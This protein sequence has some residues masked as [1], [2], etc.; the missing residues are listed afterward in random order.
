M[1]CWE[2]VAKRGC[3]VL[4]LLLLYVELEY[5]L[6]DLYAVSRPMKVVVVRALTGEV[7]G[8]DFLVGLTFCMFTCKL[9]GV[10]CK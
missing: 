4:V 2:Y 8:G 9:V 7:V 5:L 1:A 3:V 6:G 10:V